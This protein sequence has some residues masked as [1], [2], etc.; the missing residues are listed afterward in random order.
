VRSIV[1]L[2]IYV[3]LHCINAYPVAAGASMAKGWA[4]GL[5]THGASAVYEAGKTLQ[6]GYKAAT[7]KTQAQGNYH[8]KK[9]GAGVFGAGDQ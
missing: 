9:F 4:T 1:A 6:H 8:T 5:A 2:A 7:A 3:S